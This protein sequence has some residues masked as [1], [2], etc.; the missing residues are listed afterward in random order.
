MVTS[1]VAKELFPRRRKRNIPST[2]RLTIRTGRAPPEMRGNGM[3]VM[4][5]LPVFV[6]IVLIGSLPIWRHSKNW[7]FYPLAP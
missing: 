4:V 7:G 1:D 3:M 6:L 2:T 5:V